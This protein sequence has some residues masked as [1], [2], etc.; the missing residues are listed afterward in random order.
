M[1]T[2]QPIVHRINVGVTKCYLLRCQDGYL[3]IDTSYRGDFDKLKV[4]LTKLGVAL[5]DIRY[6]LLT[7]HHDDHAGFAAQLVA[8]TGCR[9]IVH[10]DAVPYL[11]AGKA[12]NTSRPLN[13]CIKLVFS[14]FSLFHREFSYP[15]LTLTEQDIVVSGDDDNVLRSIG[16]DGMVLH[17]PG[18]TEDSISVLLA[19]GTVFAGDVAM[20]FLNFCRIKYR[21]IYVQDIDLVFESWRKLI[22]HGA[23]KI[24]PAH[25]EPFSADKLVF[26]GNK[27]KEQEAEGKR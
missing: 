7:H 15:P 2:I 3:L 19:D 26:Y 17:T 13:G 9:V 23:K 10:E 11:K 4:A 22:D 12:E 24:Y 27:F 20:N 14:I 1:S 25:G 16:I 18:H 5:A 6:L 21:P 8:Q